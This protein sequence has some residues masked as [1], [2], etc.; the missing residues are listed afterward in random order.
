MKSKTTRLLYT[1]V[2]KFLYAS[3]SLTDQ[4]MM[5]ILYGFAM[6]HF[7]PVKCTHVLLSVILGLAPT[8]FCP[9]FFHFM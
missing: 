1:S 9:R 7:Y 6:V 8:N 2:Y 5:R 3:N 4:I